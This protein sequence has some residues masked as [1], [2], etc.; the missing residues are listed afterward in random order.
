MVSMQTS[1]AQES[2]PPYLTGGFPGVVLLGRVGIVAAGS[3]SF[4]LPWLG[5]VSVAKLRRR[6]GREAVLVGVSQPWNG[7]P[8][9]AAPLVDTPGAAGVGG[10]LDGLPEPA[11]GVPSSVGAGECVG[12]PADG[13]GVAGGHDLVA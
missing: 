11:G 6:G 3:A 1:V 5:G 4:S 13:A 7:V 2:G 12:E 10:N 9:E 8:G